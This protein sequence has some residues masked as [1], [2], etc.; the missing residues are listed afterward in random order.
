MD[1]L[2]ILLSK[3]LVILIVYLRPILTQAIS[4][5]N[6]LKL[7]EEF[8]ESEKGQILCLV[9]SDFQKLDFHW[10]KDGEQYPPPNLKNVKQVDEPTTSR[11]IIDVLDASHSG[12]YTCVVKNG[13]QSE[14]GTAVVNVKV[15]PRW[16]IEPKDTSVQE[17]GKAILDC[18]ADGY[19]EPTIK[20]KKMGDG[21]NDYIPIQNVPHVQIAA[22]NSLIVMPA[23]KSHTGFYLCSAS[24]GFGSDLSKLIKLTV[25]VPPKIDSHYN[26]KIV[27]SGS[28]VSLPCQSFGDQPL[29]FDWRKGNK[30]IKND[31]YNR[32]EFKKEIKQMFV[33]S[34]LT[35]NDIQ[36]SDEGVFTCFVENLFG[37][38]QLHIKIT[39][40]ERPQHPIEVKLER[41]WSRSAKIT[42][43]IF[44]NNN[45]KPLQYI[46]EY[47]SISDPEGIHKNNSIPGS[48]TWFII[49][50]LQPASKYRAQVYAENNIGISQP[51][52]QIVFTT[53]NEEP[54]AS[55]K[56]CHLEEVGAT[57]ARISWR[58]PS[59]RHWNGELIGFYIG[60]KI[61][62]SNSVYSYHTVSLMGDIHSFILRNLRK[63]TRYTVII[64]AYNS[65]G[66]GPPSEELQFRTKEED[67][68]PQPV[69]YIENLTPTSINLHWT[70]SSRENTITGFTISYRK[71]GHQ[72]KEISIPISN[73]RKFS[74]IDLESDQLYHLLIVA[75]SDFGNSEPSEIASVRTTGVGI[76]T[77][78]NKDTDNKQ[79]EEVTKLLY[80]IIPVCSA[81]VV[82]VIV[83]A[84][85]CLY[86]YSKRTPVAVP[87]P[88]M[89]CSKDVFH[90]TPTMLPRAAHML[91]S[92]HDPPYKLSPYATMPL[93]H[94]DKEEEPI[95]ESVVDEMRNTM[96]KKEKELQL[97][98]LKV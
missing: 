89:P 56:D 64:K 39:V 41:S 74:L 32:Y 29:Q 12:H 70:V 62:S 60:Y 67:P 68:A 16:K 27:E 47:W 87:A 37:Q 44:S 81:I 95:Y 6:L 45:N 3:I 57:Y 75:N 55:P 25:Y 76:Q 22:N 96:K 82:I 8:I 15:S 86:V 13:Q 49:N 30:S 84:V 9:L 79:D 53:G 20:W 92:H 28:S 77:I 88:Y 11:L 17:D 73:Q 2:W 83:I 71:E 93:T 24:S 1:K 65:V 23:L 14:R 58:P 33:T 5:V 63:Y 46:I 91:S 10:L 19:P 61:T 52:E 7:P 72:W 54:S 43:S 38:D 90:Y 59:N 40:L 21:P 35:I 66:T 98:T 51:S 18:S 34:V 78:H 4:K 42:W 94:F 36:K 97:K 69:L 80:I 26:S 50:D 48:V 85:A 31:R